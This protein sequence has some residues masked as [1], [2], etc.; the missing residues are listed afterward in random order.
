MI[1]L[2]LKISNNHEKLVSYDE[3]ATNEALGL[4]NELV[5]ELY[6]EYHEKHSQTYWHL[7]L[8]SW[9]GNFIPYFYR[10]K[11][12]LEKIIEKYG[13]K[14]I[15]V[16]LLKE[17]SL[18]RVQ[19]DSDFLKLMSESSFSHWLLSRL[20]EANKPSALLIEYSDIKVRVTKN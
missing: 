9:L 11:I 8:F 19:N 15:K 7:I 20:I 3:K 10:K 17:N 1:T 5:K 16:K 4:I 13:D 12:L 14:K 18:R 2:G 6:P